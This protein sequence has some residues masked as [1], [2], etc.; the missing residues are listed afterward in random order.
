YEHLNPKQKQ[1]LISAIQDANDLNTAQNAFN[2]A[3]NVNTNMKSLKDIVKEFT[4]KNVTNLD[5]YKFA[6]DPAKQ[7][8]DDVF[9]SAKE[10]INS[11]QNDGNTNPSLTTL[12]ADNLTLGSV[13]EAFAN[14]DGLKNKAIKAVK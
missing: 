1:D 10:L 5:D 6:S 11:T 2:D 3:A 4:D 9:A 7:H 12:I 13:K 14:L 8:Y